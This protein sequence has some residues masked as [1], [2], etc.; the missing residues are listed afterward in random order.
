MR[1]TSCVESLCETNRIYHGSPMQTEKSQI[2]GKR[3][4]PETR[5]CETYHASINDWS[6][7]NLFPIV[8]PL[9]DFTGGVVSMTIAAEVLFECLPVKSYPENKH[10]M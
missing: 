8:I 9:F 10:T 5:L 3:I 6:V 7:I 1:K 4:M 2:E